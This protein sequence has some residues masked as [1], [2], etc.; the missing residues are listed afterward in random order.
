IAPLDLRGAEPPAHVKGPFMSAD[1]RQ[2]HI[3]LI[4]DT[5]EILDLM[6]ELLE[7]E[8][9]RVTT[10]LARLDTGKI[11]ALAPDLIIQDMLFAETQEQGWKILTLAQ[12]DP[13]LARIPF[14]L[15]TAAIRTVNNPEMAQQLDHLGIR[16][17][18]KPFNI[19]DLLA[20]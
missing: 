13:E 19:E 20:A 18:L 1:G 8:G 12:L 11:K 9:Y 7:G 4:D 3:L 15:C 17:V 10:S 14:I 2:L 16:I 6:A 5:Q